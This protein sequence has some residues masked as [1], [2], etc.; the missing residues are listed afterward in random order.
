M[1]S[2]LQRGKTLCSPHAIAMAES[3]MPQSQN[4]LDGVED[5]HQRA[6]LARFELTTQW[7]SMLQAFTID[8]YPMSLG[9]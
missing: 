2:S 3:A 1:F 7:A 8:D 9:E 6:E 5:Q 4:L